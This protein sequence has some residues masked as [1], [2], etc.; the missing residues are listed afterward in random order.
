METRIY[1][2]VAVENAPVLKPQLGV[3]AT[4]TFRAIGGGIAREESGLA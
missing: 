4:S 1:K 3:A 2:L